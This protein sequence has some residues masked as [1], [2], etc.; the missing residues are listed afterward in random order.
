MATDVGLITLIKLVTKPPQRHR[1]LRE[2]SEKSNKDG[3][4]SKEIELWATPGG[5]RLNL[6][7]LEESRKRGDLIEMYKLLTQKENVDYFQKEDN[8]H[9]KRGHR[10]TCSSKVFIPSVRTNLRKSF[11]NHWALDSWNRL[12]QVVVDADTVQTFKARYDRFIKDM[13]N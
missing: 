2:R 1:L 10:P 8:Q 11:F 4:W 7:T 3:F 6:T 13:E 12:P 9:R 5:E